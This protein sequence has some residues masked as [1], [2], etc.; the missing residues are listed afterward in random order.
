MLRVNNYVSLVN[1]KVQDNEKAPLISKNTN[2]SAIKKKDNDNNPNRQH[3][4]KNE[5]P[6]KNNTVKQPSICDGCI[7]L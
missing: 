1:E 7:V 3:T 2:Y 5:I 6:D 4:V